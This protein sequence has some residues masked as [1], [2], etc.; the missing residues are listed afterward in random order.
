[1]TKEYGLTCEE[2][3][4]ELYKKVDELWKD[5]NQGMIKPSEV[6]EL[7][8][9]IIIDLGCAVEWIYNDG[10]DGY[11]LANQEMKQTNPHVI[12]PLI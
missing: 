5:R 10:D 3:C 2:A 9:N 7:V 6:A 8:Y 11:T 12:S 4:T 1:M